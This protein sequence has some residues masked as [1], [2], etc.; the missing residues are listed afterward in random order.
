MNV[1][2]INKQT[3]IPGLEGEDPS[4][5]TT[6]GFPVSLMVLRSTAVRDGPDT[7]GTR[8]SGRPA[9]QAA[10]KKWQKEGDNKKGTRTESFSKNYHI[11]R[12]R[13]K[14]ISWFGLEPSSHAYGTVGYVR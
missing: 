1:G 13:I 3:S 14:C 8:V 6:A 2:I 5:G 12:V 7:G 11:L 10:P 9:D 4:E